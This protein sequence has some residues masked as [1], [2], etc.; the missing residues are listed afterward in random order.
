[1][2]S[3]LTLYERGEMP[4]DQTWVHLIDSIMGSELGVW[5]ILLIVV[6]GGCMASLVIVTIKNLPYRQRNREKELDI[7][8][9]REQRKSEEIRL[10]HES[11]LRSAELQAQLLAQ[12]EQM[13]VSVD[14][15]TVQTAALNASIEESKHGS[16]E[17]RDTALDSNAKLGV[18]AVQVDEIHGA[19]VRREAS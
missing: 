3:T 2:G 13:K 12:N 5:I 1:M 6:F 15:L 16:R 17:L 7:A 18:M 8:D 9:K 11:D 19:V 10:R 4:T 14:A